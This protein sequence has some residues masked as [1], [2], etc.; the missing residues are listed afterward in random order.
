MKPRE[1]DTTK[2]RLLRSAERLFA[3]HG[4]DA[5]S[6]RSIC[7]DADQRNKT[8]LQ[9]HFGSKQK[10]IEAILEARMGAIDV[11]RAAILERI[12][13]E[14]RE[15]D[16]HELVGALII[17]FTEQLCDDDGGRDYVRFAAELFSRGNAV[18]LL[19]AQ[20]PWAEAFHSVIELIGH[21]LAELPEAVIANRLE[22][23]ATQM[24]HATAAKEFDLGDAKPSERAR[25][26][27]LFSADL[28]DY[29]VGGLTARVSSGRTEDES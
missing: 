27:E 14:G 15:G 23:M 16:L 3:Q 29:L 5:V 28:I 17:P 1:P 21:C 4:I 18:E 22:L 24:V 20:R 6:M 13:R 12:R 8:A 2:Q 19:A 7:I 26:V 25:R 10:L 11:R 9:Y